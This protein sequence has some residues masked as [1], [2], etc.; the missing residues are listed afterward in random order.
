MQDNKFKKM[1]LSD[2]EKERKAENFIGFEEIPLSATEKSKERV[3]VK[4]RKKPF[5]LRLPESLYDDLKEMN[6][7]TGISLNA[8]CLDLLRPAIKKKLTELKE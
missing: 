6:A 5:P 8:I 1:P 4:E 7:I 2:K 3:L